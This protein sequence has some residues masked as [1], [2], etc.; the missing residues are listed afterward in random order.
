MEG[1]TGVLGKKGGLNDKTQLLGPNPSWDC[2]WLGS[3]GGE[4]AAGSW[5]RCLA[6]L[7][8]SGACGPALMGSSDKTRVTNPV[9]PPHP[10]MGPASRGPAVLPPCGRAPCVLPRGNTCREKSHFKVVL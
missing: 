1:L 7:Q 8:G 3:A 4:A 9:L 10:A 5:L 2:L 6:L